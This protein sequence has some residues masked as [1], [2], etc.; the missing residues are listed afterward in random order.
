MAVMYRKYLPIAS[1]LDEVIYMGRI[2]IVM[3]MLAS[4]AIA[5]DGLCHYSVERSTH[6]LTTGHVGQTYRHYNKGLCKND[7]PNGRQ[8]GNSVGPTCPMLI[9]ERCCEFKLPLHTHGAGEGCKDHWTSHSWQLSKPPWTPEIPH[10][11]DARSTHC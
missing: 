4:L 2:M 5:K 11:T 7:M 8:G 10:R 3:S 1:L 9:L 6:L